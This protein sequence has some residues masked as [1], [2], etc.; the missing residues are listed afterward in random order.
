MWTVAILGALFFMAARARA[1][2]T[3]IP[4]DTPLPAPRYANFSGL[5]R[6]Q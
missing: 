5:W 4:N 1:R 3:I 2:V 6:T